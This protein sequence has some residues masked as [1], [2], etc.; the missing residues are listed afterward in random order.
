MRKDYGGWQDHNQPHRFK[1]R[2]DFEKPI[3]L[4]GCNNITSP[5]WRDAPQIGL[6]TPGDAAYGIFD[7]FLSYQT[8]DNGWITV[9]DTG[10]TVAAGTEAG[11]TVVLTNHTDDNDAAIIYLSGKPFDCATGKTIWF[12]A[13]VKMTEANDNDANAYVGLTAGTVATAVP[14]TVDGGGPTADHAIGFFKL[15]D[16]TTWSA[17][18]TATGAT[19]T[20][21]VKAI[22]TSYIRFG[23]IAKTTEIQ[24]YV[25]DVL[26]ATH[27]TTANIPTNSMC[28]VFAVKGKGTSNVMT[29]DWV[30][31]IQ[32]R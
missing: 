11:G 19:T 25:D 21:D 2:V 12:E 22:S 26:V 4:K 27:T 13:R 31:C 29:V 7:D 30:K 1:Q 16:G 20:A 3:V 24:Y 8:T 15:E 9:I 28:P 23:F 18:N 10:S 14:L 6:C 17:E 5:I 32:L